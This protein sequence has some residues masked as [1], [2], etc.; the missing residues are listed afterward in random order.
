MTVHVCMKQI[1]ENIY[2]NL[3]TVTLDSETVMV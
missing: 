3:L 2:Q 1:F